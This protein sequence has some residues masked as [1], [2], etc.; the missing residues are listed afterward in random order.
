MIRT[1]GFIIIILSCIRDDL[2]G[3]Y[4]MTFIQHNI[5]GWLILKVFFLIRQVNIVK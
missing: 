1:C 5:P 2:L 4:L 3:S